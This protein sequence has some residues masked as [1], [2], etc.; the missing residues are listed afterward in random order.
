LLA[1]DIAQRPEVPPGQ[2]HRAMIFRS[3]ALFDQKGNGKAI[4]KNDFFKFAAST[5]TR[6]AKIISFARRSC[7]AV[8]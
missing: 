3:A 1:P 4:N 5:E 6:D 2:S 7:Q 8:S